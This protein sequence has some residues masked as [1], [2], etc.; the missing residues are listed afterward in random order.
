M[1][2][3]LIEKHLSP[4]AK[5]ELDA[6][7][8]KV[9]SNSQEKADWLSEY[10]RDVEPKVERGGEALRHAGK[11]PDIF[12][13]MAT[14]ERFLFSLL[15]DLKISLKDI[16]RQLRANQ[17][18]CRAALRLSTNPRYY[19]E[20]ILLLM[21]DILTLTQNPD[22]YLFGFA[23]YDMI[24]SLYLIIDCHE[25]RGERH[26]EEFLDRHFPPFAEKLNAT[27]VSLGLRT[28]KQSTDH[29]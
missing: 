26:F 28:E 29:Q 17:S 1:N 20:A 16:P 23:H 18:V 5:N 9:E 14:T 27:A 3:R 13:Y 12:E 24:E 11:M 2:V 7:I 10:M 6:A 22:S 4:A 8:K 19:Q 25:A 21:D 15:M